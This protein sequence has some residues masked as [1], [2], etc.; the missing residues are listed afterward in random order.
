MPDPKAA[1]AYPVTLQVDYPDHDLNRATSVFRVILIVPI[2]IILF[3]VSGPGWDAKE[4]VRFP[5]MAGGILFLPTVLM[6]LFRWKYPR[7][8]FDWNLALSRFGLR[9]GAFFFLLT[10]R[11]PSTDEEQS[12]HL[13]MPY[14]DV[15]KDLKAGL[16][17]VKWFLAIPHYIVLAFLLVG[18]IGAVIISW[19]AILF[20]A[21]YPRGLF[22][23]VV[24][25]MRWCTRVSAYAFVLVTDVYPPFSLN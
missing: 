19:F 23:Y 3:L 16:P 4:A 14:P 25:V 8:W 20:T 10:D 12:V 17:L 1:P 7:W 13:K 24:G 11:Y 5:F 2:A 15:R 6:I 22:D 9:V 21:R 18:A